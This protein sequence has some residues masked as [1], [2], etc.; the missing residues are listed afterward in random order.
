MMIMKLIMQF[1]K[2]FGNIWKNLI[3]KI[4]EI[5]LSEAEFVVEELFGQYVR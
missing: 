1:Y 4:L 3:A 2:R 5:K